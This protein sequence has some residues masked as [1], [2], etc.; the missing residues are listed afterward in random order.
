M[1]QIYNAPDCEII[2][3]A[4]TDVVTTSD[5]AIIING[6]DIGAGDIPLPEV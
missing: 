5:P 6:S 1:K 4:D 2:N 3:L